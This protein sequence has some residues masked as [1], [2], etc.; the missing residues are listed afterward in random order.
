MDELLT[1]KQVA[2]LLQLHEMTIRRYIKSG[3]LESVR[4]GRNVRVPRRAVE[5][6]LQAQNATLREVPSVYQVRENDDSG[7]AFTQGISTDEDARDSFLSW[8][9]DILQAAKRGEMIPI[10]DKEDKV[11]QLAGFITS[12]I[13]HVSDRHDEFI[14]MAVYEDGLKP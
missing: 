6:L 12:D 1:I 13:P 7:D 4:I 14:G 9:E 2:Q 11:L 3:K 5:A 8:V 10:P